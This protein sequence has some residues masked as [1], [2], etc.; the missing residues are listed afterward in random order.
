MGISGSGKYLAYTGKDNTLR[1]LD[2]TTKEA[3]EIQAKT[4]AN[5]RIQRIVF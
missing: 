2:L 1:V 5:T 4:E 3:I